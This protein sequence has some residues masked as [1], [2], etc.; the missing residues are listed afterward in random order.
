MNAYTSIEILGDFDFYTP[1]TRPELAPGDALFMRRTSDGLDWY[2][3]WAHRAD[4][5]DP[6]DVLATVLPDDRGAVIQ[7]V[8]R[9]TPR[10]ADASGQRAHHRDSGRG[11]H[12]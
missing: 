2:E 9:A 10:A 4:A 6:N 12:D 8:L 11:P 3:N 5:F 7:C 1:D